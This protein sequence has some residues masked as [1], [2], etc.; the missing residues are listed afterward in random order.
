MEK[1]EIKKLIEKAQFWSHLG[2][3]KDAQKLFAQAIKGIEKTK[4]KDVDMEF[5]ARIGYMNSLYDSGDPELQLASFPPLLSLIDQYPNRFEHESAVYWFYKWVIGGVTS[6]DYI[7]KDRILTLVEDMKR[8]YLTSGYG[9]KVIDYFLQSIYF[10]LGEMELSQKHRE[11]WLSYTEPSEMDDCTACVINRNVWF[12]MALGEYE[13]SIEEAQPIL[14]GTHTC[15]QVPKSTI[16][17]VIF[18]YL[19]LGKLEECEELYKKG[20]EELNHDSA[21]LDEYGRFL[22]YLSIKK[23]FKNAHD[24]IENHFKYVWEYKSKKEIMI[25]YTSMLV[26]FR[27][28]EKEGKEYIK[29]EA[30]HVTPVNRGEDGYL[31]SDLINY[32]DIEQEKIIDLYNQR[33]GNNH[34]TVFY[35]ER[36]EK[37]FAQYFD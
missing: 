8:R 17:R 18:D 19:F 4:E 29:C 27:A 6:F 12:H 30:L 25:F 28:L 26:Y 7:S 37:L 11:K 10:D 24:I 33:N 13:K 23:D 16:P 3:R 5:E 31:I 2:G 20:I 34:Y 36:Y 21:D 22:V 32:F 35:K 15:G 1:E 9:E 14:D